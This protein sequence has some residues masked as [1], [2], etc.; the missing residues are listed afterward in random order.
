MTYEQFKTAQDALEARYMA[1]CSN[2]QQWDWARLPNG[3]TPDCIKALPAWQT[4]KA[5]NKKA[6]ADVQA[7]NR[8]YAGKFK[9]EIYA[10]IDA[11]RQRIL[12]SC[13]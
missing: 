7:F 1:S 11:K 13:K 9:K 4:A 10:A 5:N 3:L 2:V 8:L 12:E 6:F